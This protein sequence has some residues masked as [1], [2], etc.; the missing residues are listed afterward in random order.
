M[1][2]FV[3]GA[4]LRQ[5]FI[6]LRGKTFASLPIQWKGSC[7]GMR[8]FPRRRLPAI[9]GQAAATG[10]PYS[11]LLPACIICMKKPPNGTIRLS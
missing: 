3:L 1:A 4:N 11:N 6:L 5:R 2:G 9:P 7:T 8:I 10:S